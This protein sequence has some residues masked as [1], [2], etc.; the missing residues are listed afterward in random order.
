MKYYKVLKNSEYI[1][2]GSSYDLRKY[3][4]KHNIIIIAD[5]EHAQFIQIDENFYRDS[6]MCK[7][8][9]EFDGYEIAQVVEIDGEEYEALR[10][11]NSVEEIVKIAERKEEVKSVSEPENISEI[12][13]VREMKIKELSLQCSKE[14]MYGFDWDSKHYS[15]S[16]EDQIELQHLAFQA[17]KDRNSMYQYHADNSPYVE[18]SANEILE[19]YDAYQLHKNQHRI[20][21]NKLKSYVNQ[22]STIKEISGVYYG[23]TIPE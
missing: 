13:Y 12:E 2:V 8:D 17:E 5:E 22:L 7:L 21:F 23:I 3:Q 4:K 16:I 15:M 19:L 20:Y 10:A 6:W 11:A 14:I 9:D 18:M 1:G